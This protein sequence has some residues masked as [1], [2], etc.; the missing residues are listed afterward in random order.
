MNNFFKDKVVIVTFLFVGL[1]SC[2]NETNLLPFKKH[3]DQELKLWT[4]TFSHFNLADFKMDT[5]LHFEKGSS[6]DFNEYNKFMSTYKPIITFSPD[7]SKFID[8]YSVQLNLQKEGDQRSA[9]RLN[10]FSW[11]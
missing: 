5:I 8:I 4:N 2:R 11:P 9:A 6:Q 1:L 7:G 10:C 3:F